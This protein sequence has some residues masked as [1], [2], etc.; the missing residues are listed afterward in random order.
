MLLLF[1]TVQP[2]TIKT[3]MLA[4]GQRLPLVVDNH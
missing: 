3:D 1:T 2:I 4:V